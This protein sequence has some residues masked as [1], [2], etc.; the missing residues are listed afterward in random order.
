MG[1]RSATVVFAALLCVCGMADISVYSQS[2][3]IDAPV[4][5]TPVR[6]TTIITADPDA[7]LCFYRD[8]LGFSVEYDRH[9]SDSGTLSLLAPGASEGRVIALRYGER[10]GGSVGL[11]WTPGLPPQK[12]YVTPAQTGAVGI[13]LLTDDLPALRQRLDAAGIAE[14]TPPVSYSE[15]RGPTDVY[16]VFDPNCVRVSFAQIANETKQESLNR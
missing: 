16:M 7:S 8:V 4:Q 1:F 3:T 15:S 9:V 14:A 10:L 2:L 5:L 6:R 12:P 13:L 11:F